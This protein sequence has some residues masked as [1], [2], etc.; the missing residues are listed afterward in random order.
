M[1]TN[2]SSK[3]HKNTKD[4]ASTTMKSYYLGLEGTKKDELIQGAQKHDKDL[5]NNIVGLVKEKANME[6]SFCDLGIQSHK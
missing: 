2:V 4:L 5:T 6:C 3:H 1:K